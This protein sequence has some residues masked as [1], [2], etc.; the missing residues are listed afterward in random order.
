MTELAATKARYPAS[1]DRDSE[2]C[3]LADQK[4]I[5][6]KRVAKLIVEVLLSTSLA[7]SALQNHKARVYHELEFTNHV[8]SR[9]QISKNMCHNSLM[10]NG[11]SMHKVAYF[12]DRVSNIVL[13][14]SEILQLTNNTMKQSFIIKGLTITQ[15][16]LVSRSRWSRNITTGSHTHL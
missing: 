4:A 8:W 13:G 10:M 12:I 3:F 2:S 5:D 14:E 7:Q 15:C 1:V 11:G 6:P 9:L 16:K